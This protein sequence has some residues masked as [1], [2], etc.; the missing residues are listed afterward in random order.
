VKEHRAIIYLPPYMPVKL[1]TVQLGNKGQLFHDENK[2]IYGFN[3]D[4][5]NR[6]SRTLEKYSISCLCVT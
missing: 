5:N 6:I 4:Y 2:N 3:E 1:E